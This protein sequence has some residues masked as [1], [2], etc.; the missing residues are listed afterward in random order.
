M[1]KFLIDYTILFI[2]IL[3]L[4]SICLYLISGKFNDQISLIQG[5]SIELKYFGV[6][7]FYLFFTLGIY[8]FGVKK[9]LKIL[10]IFILG[11]FAYGTFELTNYSIFKDWK[12]SIVLIDTLCGG[13]LLSS[14]VYLFRI[15]KNII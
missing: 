1:T 11:L 5:Q 8:Y 15:I 4:D 12:F 9:N 14:V 2:L 6:I 3:L 13:V 10:D 7:L